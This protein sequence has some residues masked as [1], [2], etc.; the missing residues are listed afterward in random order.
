LRGI[1]VEARMALVID[2]PAVAAAADT[3]GLFVAG[4][5]RS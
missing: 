4:I 3:A 5:K 1:A 2:R